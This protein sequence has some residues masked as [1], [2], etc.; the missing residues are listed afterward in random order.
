MVSSTSCIAKVAVDG[1]LTHRDV[2]AV[3]FVGSTPIAEYVHHTA[4][5]TTRGAGAG[6]RQKSH[7]GDARR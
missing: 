7:G 2:A 4:A 3:S 5:P 6:W 1:L